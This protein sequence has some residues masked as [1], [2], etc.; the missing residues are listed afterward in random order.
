ML[1]L[2]RNSIYF[3]CS[4]EWAYFPPCMPYNFLLK[5]WHF[6]YYNVVTLEI[7]FFSLPGL[8]LL[9]FLRTAFI[10]LFSDSSKLFLPRLFLSCVV[11]EVSIRYLR[12]Q[13]LT[14][15][16]LKE[17]KKNTLPLFVNWL[18][19]RALCQPLARPPTVLPLPSPPACGTKLCPKVWRDTSLASSKSFLSLCLVLGMCIALWIHVSSSS[20]FSFLGFWS[21][22]CLPHRHLPQEVW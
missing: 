19:T 13:L 17:R 7:R 10:C 12:G 15:E 14:W 22:Y 11:T 21:D 1:G 8:L 6:A 9:L 2:H 16:S 18:W 20:A 3:F 4:C 5:N